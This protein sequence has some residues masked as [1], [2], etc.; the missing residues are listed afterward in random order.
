VAKTVIGLTKK[1]SVHKMVEELVYEKE[2]NLFKTATIQELLFD[3]FSVSSLK[4]FLEDPKMVINGKSP[5][6]LEAMK[7]GM[8]ALYKDV[9]T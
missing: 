8:L 2:E 5:H 1:E 9:S 3:G 7:D 4:D 6:F